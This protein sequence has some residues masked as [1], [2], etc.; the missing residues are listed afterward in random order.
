MCEG[1]GARVYREPVV[2]DIGEDVG[3]L[4]IYTTETARGRELEVSPK[5][6]DSR[7]VHTDVAERRFNGRTVFAAV[8]LPLVAGDYTIWGPDPTCPTE[9]TIVGGTVIEVDWR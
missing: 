6:D 2:L 9:V 7:R 8:Y 4:I 5:S 1:Q 3:G